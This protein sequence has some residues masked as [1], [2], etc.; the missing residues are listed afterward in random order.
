[1]EIESNANKIPSSNGIVNFDYD[2]IKQKKMDLLKT[3]PLINHTKVEPQLEDSLNTYLGLGKQVKNYSYNNSLRNNKN[4]SNV[5]TMITNINGFDIDDYGSNFPSE[6][7]DLRNTIT[8]ADFFDSLIRKQQEMQGIIQPAPIKTPVTQQ[9][10]GDKPNKKSLW[11]A[12]ADPAGDDSRYGKLSI[13]GFVAR[14]GS[15]I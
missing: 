15:K 3:L 12:T 13:S 2:E 9:P 7:F 1:M 11:D 4:F 10:T 14:H 5:E 8:E 6:V